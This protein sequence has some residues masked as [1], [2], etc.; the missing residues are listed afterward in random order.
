M[1]AILQNGNEIVSE[2]THELRQLLL[3][4]LDKKG[5]LSEIRANLRANVFCALY[6]QK[7]A[8]GMP[9]SAQVEKLRSSEY[10][11]MSLELVR[12]FLSSLGLQHTLSVFNHE[13]GTS[14]SLW[15]RDAIESA[16]RDSDMLMERARDVLREI[17]APTAGRDSGQNNQTGLPSGLPLVAAVVAALSTDPSLFVRQERSGAD[18]APMPAPV[19]PPVSGAEKE[20]VA[21]AVPPS[22]ARAPTTSASAP[23]VSTMRR[24]PPP[25]VPTASPLQA[26]QHEKGQA[27]VD[28]KGGHDEEGERSKE[29][30][31]ENKA[32]ELEDA[33][34]MSSGSSSGLRDVTSS[35]YGDGGT[36]ALADVKTSSTADKAVSTGSGGSGH[37][38]H[39][40]HDDRGAGG[41]LEGAGEREGEGGGEGGGAL[42]LRS[43][44]R[45]QAVS[46]GGS[47]LDSG[48]TSLLTSHEDEALAMALFSPHKPAVPDG[49]SSGRRPRAPRGAGRLAAAVEALDGSPIMR[50]WSCGVCRRSN[51]S[52]AESCVVCFTPRSG[53]SGSRS[54]FEDAP[55]TTAETKSKSA[56]AELMA[57]PSRRGSSEL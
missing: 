42:G 2:K 16:S 8:E 6:E 23:T 5:V 51:S 27:L 25:A 32:K 45:V 46:P 24:R 7:E 11:M 35:S 18:V 47:T 43:P 34:F 40:D 56:I 48:P 21:E 36:G 22:P 50:P 33:S 28:G 10:G 37:D 30:E 13:I 12:D 26:P 20:P 53:S 52:S 14:S 49:L 55:A 57:S 54:T 15:Q 1:E 17:A 38:D 19:A 44:S 31:T 4:T 39:A 9:S 3:Q 29:E 41:A